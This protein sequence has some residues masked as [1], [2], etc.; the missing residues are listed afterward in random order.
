VI[1]AELLALL[2]CPRCGGVLG[3]A[4]NGEEP[5]VCTGC[6]GRFPVVRGIPRFAPPQQD[7]FARRTKASF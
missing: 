6:A 7:D 2:R 1:D 5:L 4:V 3:A